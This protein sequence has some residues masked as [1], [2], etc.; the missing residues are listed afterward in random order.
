HSRVALVKELPAGVPISYSR[1]TTLERPSRL[2]VLSAG[3]ADG[4]PMPFSTRAQV[5]LGGQRCRVM[6]RVTMDQ[7][8]VDVTDLQ[9]P[10][11]PGDQATF[12]GRQGNE[13]ITVAEFSRWG[14]SIPWECFCSI[15]KR[16]TRVYKTF[17]Q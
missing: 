11:E 3:Y 16:V 10:P 5:L 2:A 17:R 1:L 15:S 4:I 9:T 13:T 8:I 6:G 12:I 14:D 7:L